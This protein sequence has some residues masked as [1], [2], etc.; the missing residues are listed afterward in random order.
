MA[1]RPKAQSRRKQKTE[2]KAKTI[3]GAL[4]ACWN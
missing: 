1:A 2:R 3:H 4:F